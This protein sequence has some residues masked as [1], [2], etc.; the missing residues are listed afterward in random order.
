M[1]WFVEITRNKSWVIR[2]DLGTNS[3][4]IQYRQCLQPVLWP[5]INQSSPPGT[6]NFITKTKHRRFRTDWDS[7]GWVHG[8][9]LVH[10]ILYTVLLTENML[11]LREH[12]KSSANL[13]FQESFPWPG[14]VSIGP[15]WWRVYSVQSVP[16]VLY[17]S[18]GLSTRYRFCDWENKA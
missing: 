7:Q 4:W 14:G 16:S 6:P 10:G 12:L 15:Q 1:I 3:R 11:R 17:D 9:I 13:I 5:Y 2:S 8:L 18:W